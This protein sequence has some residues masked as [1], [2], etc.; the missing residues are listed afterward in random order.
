MHRVLK[1]ATYQISKPLAILFN[2]FLNSGKV[3]DIWKL[4]NVTPIQ[5]KGDKTLPINYRPIN[6]TSV[7]GKLIKTIIRDK[8]ATFLEKNNM[9]NNSQHGFCNKCSCLTNLLDFYNDVFNIYEETKAIDIIYL[10]FQKAFDKVLHKHLLKKLESHG[11]S[12]NILKW[13]EDWLSNRRQ[14]VVINSKSSNWRDVKSGVPQGSV[15]SPILFLIYV[16]D[17]DEGLICMVSKFADDTKITSKVTTIANKLQFQSI[18][19]NNQFTKY[20]MN[21]SELSKVNHEKDLGVTI[22]NDLKPSKH[23]L[24]VVMKANKLVG[25]ISI[26]CEYKSE[27]IILTLYNALV[28]PHLEY[29]IQFWS[30]YYRKDINKLERIQRRIT[31]MISRL[32]NKSYEEQLKELNLFSLSKRRL[33]GD[34]IE[35]F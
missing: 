11:M 2:K 19:S 9:I 27:K 3:S 17:I 24:H 5:K 26:T 28:R 32:R 22:S 7:V 18:S 21:S 6:L 14:H 31:K 16:N 30:P 12:G 10:D 33:R 29:Y 35:V 20:T 13:V 34:L 1:E 25:F 23:C 8:L 4:T 15:L